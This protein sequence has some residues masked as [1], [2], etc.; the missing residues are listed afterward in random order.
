MS[1]H[2][3]VFIGLV[4]AITLVFLTGLVDDIRGLKPKTKL[5]AQIL[6]AAWACWEGVRITAINDQPVASW[7]AVPLTVFWLIACTN[8]INLIDGLDGLASGVA[9][10]ATLAAL[11]AAM[12]QGNIGLVLATAPLA[13]CLVA[14]LRY[15]FNPA[16][17]FLGDSGSLT[18]GFLLGCFAVI[19][20]QKSATLIGMAAPLI[21]LSVPLMDVSLSVSRRFISNRSIFAADR[22]HIH[23]RL[24]ARGLQP[25]RAALLLYGVCGA[26]AVVAVLIGF[27]GY[28]I[29]IGLMILAC[30]FACFAIWQLRFVEFEIATQLFAGGRFRKAVEEEMSIRRLQEGLNAVQS[31]EDRWALICRASREMNFHSVTLQ[32]S[33]GVFQEKFN[34]AKEEDVCHFRLTA[35]DASLLLERRYQDCQT[36]ASIA[37]LQI[38]RATLQAEAPPPL[39]GYVLPETRGLA[40]AAAASMGHTDGGPALET[41]QTY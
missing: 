12:V 7:W 30:A 38:L 9:L 18:V 6:A 10:F 28:A 19:W 17:V 15:N 21:A 24:L 14:F 31:L 39:I 40:R 34:S 23:H 5:A 22:G 32:S 27:V 41:S 3:K 33:A 26:A 20:C 4:P 11:S 8:A 29:G 13:G 1:H 36:L 16:S 37:F 2:A 25:R 35:G